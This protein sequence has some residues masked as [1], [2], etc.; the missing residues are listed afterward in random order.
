MAIGAATSRPHCNAVEILVHWQVHFFLEN[1]P[2][3]TAL[4]REISKNPDLCS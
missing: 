1:D 3:K 4:Q 2:Q